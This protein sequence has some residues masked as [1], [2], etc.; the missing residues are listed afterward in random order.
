MGRMVVFLTV[1]QLFVFEEN[2]TSKSAIGGMVTFGGHTYVET[3]PMTWHQAEAQA[4]ALGGHLVAINSAAEQAFIVANFDLAQGQSLWMGLTDENRGNGNFGWTNGDPLTYTNWGNGEPNNIGLEHF[5]DLEQRGGLWNNY[6]TQQPL[7]GIMEFVPVAAPSVQTLAH[8]SASVYSGDQ[9]YGNYRSLGSNINVLP[10]QADNPS[11][12]AVAYAQTP[13]TTQIVVAIRGTDLNGERIAAKNLIDDSSFVTNTPT[14]FMAKDVAYAADFVKSL[15]ET[16]PEAT[17]TLTGHSLGGAI[18]QLVGEASGLTTT[19][20]N[21]PGT[22]A[23]FNQLTT[24]LSPVSGISSGGP[25]TNYRIYGDQVSLAGTQA[26]ATV[27]LPA[28]PGTHFASNT[29][30]LGDLLKNFDLYFHT[31]HSMDTVIGE[32]SQ[33]QIFQLGPN[34]V[35]T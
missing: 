3:A 15:H 19:T 22:A 32:L 26:G 18:A 23:L 21:S 28:P 16:Y 33:P 30:T 6:A 8:L 29:G 7:R 12:H 5:G 2:G 9:P 27:I 14:H 4:V 24:E 25:Q 10:Y 13:D 1:L 35:G 31:L 34:D 20:F 11:F 17:I